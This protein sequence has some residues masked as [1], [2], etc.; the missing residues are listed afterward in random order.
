MNGISNNFALHLS[1][2]TQTP[3]PHRLFLTEEFCFC[4][5]FLTNFDFEN[6]ILL[7]KK[8]SIL[9]ILLFFQIW[10]GLSKN[11]HQHFYYFHFENFDKYMQIRLHSW[12]QDRFYNCNLF[13][14]TPIKRVILLPANMLPSLEYF[15]QYFLGY[16]ALNSVLLCKNECAIE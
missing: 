13:I 8:P 7:R 1:P 6:Y 5:Q 3:L 10:I 11:W 2:V 9:R 12:G 16:W 15:Y 4:R 14:I